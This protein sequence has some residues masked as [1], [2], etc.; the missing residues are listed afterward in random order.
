M[1]IEL[2]DESEHAERACGKARDEPN[3]NPTLEPP[4]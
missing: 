4:K 2:C 1:E 3:S